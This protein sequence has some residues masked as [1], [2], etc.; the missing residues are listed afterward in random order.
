MFAA[1]RGPYLDDCVLIWMIVSSAPRTWPGPC[2]E[3][4][5]APCSAPSARACTRH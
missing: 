3:P 2:L 5:A 4:G 1:V